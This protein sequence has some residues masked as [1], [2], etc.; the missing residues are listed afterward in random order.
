MHSDVAVSSVEDGFDKDVRFIG[1]S[2]ESPFTWQK[3]WVQTRQERG[4]YFTFCPIRVNYTRI[5]FFE[6]AAEP[7]LLRV[8]GAP[9]PHH[10]GK[11]RDP[12][13]FLDSHVNLRNNFAERST[14]P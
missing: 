4:P 5:M 2:F 14:V 13:Q 6:M 10:A 11:K 12:D 9:S 3:N 1:N 8:L 7:A